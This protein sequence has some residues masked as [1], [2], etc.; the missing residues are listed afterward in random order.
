MVLNNNENRKSMRE[1]SVN[2]F[3]LA[4]YL[5]LVLLISIGLVA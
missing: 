1:D 5:S 4:D 3:L 2:H